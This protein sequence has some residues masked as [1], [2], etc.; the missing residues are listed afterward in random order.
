MT[1]IVLMGSGVVLMAVM[2]TVTAVVMVATI[3]AM[4]VGTDICR[5]GPN[6]KHRSLSRRENQSQSL[7][8]G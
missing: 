8:Y 1:V 6:R 5:R 3:L 2:L 7:S 4:L